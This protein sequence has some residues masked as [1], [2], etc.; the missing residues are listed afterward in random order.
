[1]K[2][3]VI[4]SRNMTVVKS[5]GGLTLIN[6]VRLT[7]QGEAQLAK[8][9]TVKNVVKIGH[10]HGRDD[11]YYVSE[12]GAVF[13]ALPNAKHPD[14]GTEAQ[15]SSAENLPILDAQLFVFDGANEAEAALL[16]A[17][18]NGVLVTCDAVQNWPNTARCSL[19]AKVVARLIGFTKRSAK[20][21][22]PWRKAMT[23][24]GGSLQ[25]DFER[26]AA[27][28]FDILIA[29]HGAPLVGGAPCALAA[30]VKATYTGS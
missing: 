8:L 6:A 22:P 20:I 10:Y 5:G 19:P 3:G 7:A 13:W 1:M 26:L 2:P 25:P 24:D 15:V 11:A 30:T 16:V 17:R 21:G 27:L 29:A 12:H 14:Y 18:S 23:P 4:I 9:G 28:K